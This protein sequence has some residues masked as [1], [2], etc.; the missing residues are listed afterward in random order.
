MIGTLL[1]INGIPLAMIDTLLAM[2]NVLLATTQ[3][4]ETI[5]GREAKMSDLFPIETY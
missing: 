1:A 5:L 4:L 3:L 2:N